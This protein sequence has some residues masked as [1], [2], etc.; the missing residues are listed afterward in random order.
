MF[1]K[2]TQLATSTAETRL[3]EHIRNG[4]GEHGD[5]KREAVEVNI[6]PR[7]RAT[8]LSENKKYKRFRVKVKKKTA[9][10]EETIYV[11]ELQ[12]IWRGG[13]KDYVD[14]YLQQTL[15]EQT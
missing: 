7:E 12:S 6:T 3:L 8:S 1:P 15:Q 5:N 10:L 9:T 14:E 11:R 2:P 4:N 13:V